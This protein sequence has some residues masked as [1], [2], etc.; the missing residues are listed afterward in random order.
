M[1]RIEPGR[2]DVRRCAQWY[3][4]FLTRAIAARPEP[5]SPEHARESLRLLAARRAL[6]ELTLGEALGELAQL[7]AVAHRWES[8]VELLRARLL[9]APSRLASA[10]ADLTS[11][12]DAEAVLAA[13]VLDA[14]AEAEQVAR[15]R[16]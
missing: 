16:D 12:E 11:P 6:R 2:Y 15:A 5:P 4:A 7:D 8:A 3:V 10:V 1:P 14:L 13:E 9:T